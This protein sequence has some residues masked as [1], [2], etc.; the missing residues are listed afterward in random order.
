[1]ILQSPGR[2]GLLRCQDRGLKCWSQNLSQ[3]SLWCQ[4]MVAQEWK[5]CHA[6]SSQ[7]PTQ[8][9][10]PPSDDQSGS[11]G[12]ENESLGL[13]AAD[14]L[15]LW[16]FACY[17]ADTFY[18]LLWVAEHA[19]AQLWVTW[20]KYFLLLF[21]FFNLLSHGLSLWTVVLCSWH[22]LHDTSG[23]CRLFCFLPWDIDA[24]FMLPTA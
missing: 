5:T 13:T 20:K 3:L 8:P 9:V 10:C 7:G 12:K 14:G 19:T 24:F 6:A 16:Q 17:F 4:C 2:D 18:N 21:D 15:V 22:G 23:S 11:L 1:M